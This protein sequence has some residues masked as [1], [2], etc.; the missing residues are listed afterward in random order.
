MRKPLTA[1]IRHKNQVTLP[2]K[3][4][5]RTA[6]AEGDFLTFE[7]VTEPKMIEAG[8]V[9]LRPQH[10]SAKPASQVGDADSE[11]EATFPGVR[12]AIEALKKSV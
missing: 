11:I 10:L 3:L 5:D 8:V 6:L 12:S 7:L 9:V 1:R 4:V 2:Q